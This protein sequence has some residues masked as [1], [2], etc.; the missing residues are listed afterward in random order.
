VLEGVSLLNTSRTEDNELWDIVDAW[1]LFDDVQMG[2]SFIR[3]H[4]LLRRKP[5]YYVLNIILP[6]LVLS[7][8][9]LLVF[10]LPADSGEKMG[11]AVTVVL[12]FTVAQDTMSNIIPKTSDSLPLISKQ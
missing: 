5:V 10:W 8:I 3:Y 4:I 9:A 7:L 2:A 11:L 6:I 1:V 12:S